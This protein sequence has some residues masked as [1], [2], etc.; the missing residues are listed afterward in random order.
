MSAR[1][2]AFMAHDEMLSIKEDK[3]HPAHIWGADSEA[4]TEEELKPAKLFFYWGESDYWVDN[5][6]RDK[7]ISEKAKH[8][9]EMRIDTHGMDHCFSLD[10]THGKLV[11][12]QVAAW[13]D[14]FLQ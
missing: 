6:V 12:E 11:A 10:E 14:S 8:G 2:A 1:Q 3:W 9:T 7:L 5:G 13:I 4:E